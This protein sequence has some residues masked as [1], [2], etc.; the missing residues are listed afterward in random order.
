MMSQPAAAARNMGFSRATTFVTTDPEQPPAAD[1]VPIL[2]VEDEAPQ[3]DALSRFLSRNGFAVRAVESAEEALSLL[4]RHAFA[5]LITDLRLPGLDGVELVR[6]ARQID[7]EL[8]LLLVTAHASVETAVE[9]LRA[10]AHDYILK[11]LFYEELV[12]KLRNLIR[13]RELLAENDRLRAALHQRGGPEIIGA[14]PAMREVIEWVRRAAAS[15]ATVLICGETGTGKEVVAQAIHAQGPHRNE[16]MLSVNVAALPDTMVE[17]ELFGHEKGAFTGADRRRPGILRAASAGTVFLDEIGELSLA[18][19]AKLLRALEARE[20]TPVGA[21]ASVPF[22]ARILCAT[23]RNLLDHVRSGQ[24]REDLFYRINVLRIDVPPLRE[25][26][27]DVPLLAHHLLQ[28]LATRTGRQAPGIDADAMAALCT[29]P[30][31]GN[32]RELSNVLERALILCEEGDIALDLLPLKPAASERSGAPRRPVRLQDAVD[33]F[34]RQHVSEV[35]RM[36]EGNR[37]K[38]ARLLDLS[39]ATLYRRLDKL[40][41]KGFGVHRGEA[42][43]G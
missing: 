15:Q 34:E 18:V 14:S 17:S 31:P 21:D 3:R 8:G 22:R 30:W 13:H 7:A 27:E 12:R 16:P 28:R 29:Y 6:R 19:Q 42:R 36:C 5:A 9:A 38:A 23:H 24:F 35:L 1:P 39:P 25:R 10:G 43:D 11:P 40:G 37:E 41:L 33:E 2:V 32:V 20:V 4:G 26:V